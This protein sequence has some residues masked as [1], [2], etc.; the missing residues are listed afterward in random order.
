MTKDHTTSAMLDL[1]FELW[2]MKEACDRINKSIWELNK[3]D[4]FGA[5]ISP[6]VGKIE[7]KMVDALDLYF[8]EVTG[9]EVLATHMLYETGIVFD[10]KEKKYN[11]TV[12]DEFEA[13]IEYQRGRK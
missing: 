6:T 4:D 10:E 12:R 1:L 5:R 7:K 11:L 13:F 8:E 2:D 9:C 3:N